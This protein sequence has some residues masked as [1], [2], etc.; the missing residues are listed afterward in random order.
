MTDPGSGL[1]WVLLVTTAF[2]LHVGA[3]SDLGLF[4]VHPEL[5]LLVAVCA[6]LAGGPVRGAQVGFVAGVLVDLLLTS[7]LGVS[8]LA[9]ALA[10]FGVGAVQE[11]VIR[12]S[13]TISAALAAL[14]SAA[15]VLV[16]ATVAHLL[17]QRSLAD[18]NLW[19]IVGI[20]SLFN[21]VL[22]VPV[23][24]LCRWAEGPQL[25]AARP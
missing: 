14:G 23:L 12:S 2:V 20:V 6:G 24:G 5:M 7:P 10:G 9:F 13:R 22:C 3:G 17:G 16:Y 21:A 19:R 1:R 25:R 4:G 8:A 11:S 15:G 18:P